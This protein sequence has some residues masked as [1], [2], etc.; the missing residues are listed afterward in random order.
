MKSILKEVRDLSESGCKEITLLGQIINNYKASDPE[1][2]SSNNLYQKNDFAKLL[3]EINQLPGI[4]R[5]HWT[6]P[7]PIYMDDDVIDALTLPKQVN[8]LHIPVQSGS[9][10]VLKKMNSSFTLRR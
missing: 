5:I 7:H 3:W 1:Y 2:F 9:D 6:A 4:Q 8:F 10:E